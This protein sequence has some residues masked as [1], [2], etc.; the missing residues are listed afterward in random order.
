MLQTCI[1]KRKYYYIFYELN[2]EL[3]IVLRF[4]YR[5]IRWSNKL[6]YHPRESGNADSSIYIRKFSNFVQTL[7]SILT[8]QYL[9]IR[10]E[11]SIVMY[12]VNTPGTRMVNWKCREIFEAI[13]NSSVRVGLQIFVILIVD[14]LRP[15]K[16]W[17]CLSPGY[18]AVLM[19]KNICSPL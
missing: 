5:Y 9:F 3:L 13:Y 2:N 8:A 18:I 10:S 14:L 7:N 19:S 17:A 4:N 12:L 16:R 11:Y 6:F 15:C 1:R